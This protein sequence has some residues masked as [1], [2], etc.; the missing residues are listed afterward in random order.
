M[1]GYLRKQSAS[2]LTTCCPSLKIVQ[3]G[4]NACRAAPLRTTRVDALMSSR[5]KISIDEPQFQNGRRLANNKVD[6]EV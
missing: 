3:R 4:R 5:R 1:A 2:L 6:V